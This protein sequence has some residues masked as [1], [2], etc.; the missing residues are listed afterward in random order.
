L[1]SA[2]REQQPRRDTGMAFNYSLLAGGMDT[3]RAANNGDADSQE[4]LGFWHGASAKRLEILEGAPGDD[5][6]VEAMYSEALRFS[7]MAAEQG[8]SES[9]EL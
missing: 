7:E 2:S 4:T 3:V 9:Q 6:V 1:D 5:H 8:M